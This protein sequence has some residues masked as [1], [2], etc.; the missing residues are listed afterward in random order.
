MRELKAFPF[1]PNPVRFHAAFGVG[2]RPD[3]IQ[4][5]DANGVMLA[6]VQGLYQRILE[7]DREIKALEKEIARARKQLR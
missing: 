2:S 5:V 3:R 6:A 7:Q 4:S 1:G